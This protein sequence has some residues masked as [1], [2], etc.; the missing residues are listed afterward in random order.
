MNDNGWTSI[1][2]QLPENG[3]L[4]LVFIA[5]PRPPSGEIAIS[6]Y[7]RQ[8]DEWAYADSVRSNNVTHW[9]PLPNVPEA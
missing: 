1:K 5:L 6:Y 7:D 2:T 8:E 9:Q 3:Q 4:V